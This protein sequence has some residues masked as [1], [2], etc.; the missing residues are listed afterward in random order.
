MKKKI[1]VLKV[2]VPLSVIFLCGTVFASETISQN[3]A[4]APQQ[5]IDFVTGSV[6]DKTRLLSNLSISDDTPELVAS[7][8]EEALEFVQDK[9]PLLGTGSGMKELVLAAIPV[10]QVESQ[11]Q[12]ALLWNIFILYSHRVYKLS[13]ISIYVI[14][15]QRWE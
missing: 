13:Y 14:T 6:A 12:G 11:R 7:I 5:Y 10:L 1:I 15:K 4:T 8:P 3:S 2:L 9:V